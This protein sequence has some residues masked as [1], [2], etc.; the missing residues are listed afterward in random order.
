M[1]SDIEGNRVL[2]EDGNTT[3]RMVVEHPSH[4]LSDMSGTE[5][6]TGAGIIVMGLLL[7]FSTMYAIRRA[8]K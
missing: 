6:L 2:Y 7:G 8:F 1:Y 5:I 4:N 3:V